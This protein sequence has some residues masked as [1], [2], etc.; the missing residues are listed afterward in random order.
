MTLTRS[1][2]V[3]KTV[4]RHGKKFVIANC[5]VAVAS[6]GEKA[7]FTKAITFLDPSKKFGVFANTRGTASIDSS[8]LPVDIIGTMYTTKEYPSMDVL[9]S[10]SNAV[11]TTDGTS[12]GT[13]IGGVIKNAFIADVQTAQGF[14][15]Y[16]PKNTASHAEFPTIYLN[17]DGASALTASKTCYW[18]V[19]Q[20]VD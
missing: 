17:L 19:V 3:V 4:M 11:L 10:S 5:N 13:V 2:W 8:T 16:D 1:N 15:V 9:E 7:S 12:A 20:L 6:A 14:G 18:D